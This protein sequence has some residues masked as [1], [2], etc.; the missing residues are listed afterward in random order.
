MTTARAAVIER[1][2]TQM[3]FPV[4]PVAHAKVDVVWADKFY[5]I[6]WGNHTGWD[7]NGVGGGNTDLGMPFGCIYP[8][9]VVF[10][11]DHAGGLWGGLIVIWHEGLGIYTRYA[12]HRPGSC[13]VKVGQFVAAG[14]VLA[15]IGR[16]EGNAFFAH[17]H[18][19]VMRKRPPLSRSGF[20]PHW[21]FWPSNYDELLEYFIDPTRVFDK[22]DAKTPFIP[23]QNRKFGDALGLYQADD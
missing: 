22:F 7:I 1:R 13:R 18:F 8:G 12:H 2:E 21:A 16:G 10:V 19:D 3:V 11:S 20:R 15:E 4:L 17:L 6:K 23:N 5:P 14:R 9:Q